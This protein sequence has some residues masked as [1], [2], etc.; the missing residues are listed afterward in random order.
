MRLL[1]LSS[2]SI[3]LDKCHLGKK[4]ALLRGITEIAIFEVVVAL[5]PHLKKET[6]V[7]G[8][9]SKTSS[10][11]VAYVCKAANA[12]QERKTFVYS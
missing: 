5:F 3:A 2:E 7:K 8:G 12:T 6:F 9:F 1:T 11:N 10:S 4:N